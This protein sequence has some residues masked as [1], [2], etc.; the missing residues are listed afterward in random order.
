MREAGWI[1]ISIGVLL[2][3]LAIQICQAP[4]NTLLSVKG[5]C[6]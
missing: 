2:G 3:L 4:E 5:G 6:W 1:I